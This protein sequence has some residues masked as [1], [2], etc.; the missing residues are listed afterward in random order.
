MTDQGKTD[1]LAS[2]DDFAHLRVL[3]YTDKQGSRTEFY[4]LELSSL[5][6]LR[7][8]SSSATIEVKQIFSERHYIAQ[9]TKNIYESRTVADFLNTCIPLIENGTFPC[10]DLELII[11]GSIKMQAHGDA[12][13]VLSSSDDKSLL[14][15]TTK[16][17]THQ[18]FCPSIIHDVMRQPNLYHVIELPCQILGVYITFDET[19]ENL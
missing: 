13:V 12:E 7:L 16:I 10:N 3:R 5:Q 14:E 15:L 19:I 4:F 6:V 9:R 18:G 2:L 8:V 17:V 11:N 1:A